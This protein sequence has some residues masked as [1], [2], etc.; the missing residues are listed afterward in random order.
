MTASDPYRSRGHEWE[1]IERSDPI[2]WGQRPGPLSPEQLESFR[3][4]G[5]LVWP[6]LLGASEVDALRKRAAQL[7]ERP[8]LRGRDDVI[9]EPGSGAIRSIFR[10]HRDQTID[11]E[12]FAQLAA[13]PRL[14]DV[15]RQILASEV[16]VH[17]S[18]INFKPG[19][20]GREFYWHSDFETW[21]MEDGM[22][23]MRA[24]S[25]SVLLTDNSS[26]NGPLM[27]IAGSHRRYVRCAGET[28][29]NHYKQSLVAQR[30][31]VPDQQALTRLAEDGEIVEATGPAGT[32]VFFD[33]NTMHGSTGNLSPFPRHNVFLV[34]N[35][36]ENRLGAP[37]GGLPPRPEFLAEREPVSLAP[38]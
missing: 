2:C 32:V 33:C 14:A 34:Y 10:V 22:G 5:F 13:D 21:H 4:R 28:P 6:E 7:R 38:R 9:S 31:G 3:A 12:M 20:E 8:D 24:L 18:R 25:A 11:G 17:Q 27:L 26:I 30:Y 16:Y 15:A 36:V 37:Y 23:Q 35:S 19:F 1:I 29:A